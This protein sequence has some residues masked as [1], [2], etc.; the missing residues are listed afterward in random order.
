[1]V[2][3]EAREKRAEEEEEREG[4]EGEEAP[5]GVSSKE[6]ARGEAEEVKALLGDGGNGGAAEGKGEESEG[7]IDEGGI[8]KME[9]GPS[10]TGCGSLR[11]GL[12]STSS[13]EVCC[14]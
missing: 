9:V 8:W 7:K 13:K 14:T 11:C 2:G 4:D 1:L 6:K 12:D 3:G 5:I 10:A